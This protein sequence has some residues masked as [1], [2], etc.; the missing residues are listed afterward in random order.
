MSEIKD[1]FL[2]IER[3]VT[4][5]EPAKS[6]WTK[7]GVAFVNKDQSLNV[8]LDAVPLTGKLHIRERRKAKSATP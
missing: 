8:M 2:I 4:G 7:I 1:V 6:V 5:E 3:E